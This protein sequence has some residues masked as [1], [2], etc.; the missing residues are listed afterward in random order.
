MRGSVD[1]AYQHH[2]TRAEYHRVCRVHHGYEYHV[3][4]QTKGRVHPHCSRIEYT[5]VGLLGMVGAEVVD[6][7][8]EARN[9]KWSPLE[10]FDDLRPNFNDDIWMQVVDGWMAVGGKKRTGVSQKEQ[11]R[12]IT[13]D[14]FL[15]RRLCCRLEHQPSD[16]C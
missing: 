15:R 9:W 7:R 2:I 8:A 16:T 4:E 12:S 5:L 6:A 3:V 13:R 10:K 1:A 11:I 14:P